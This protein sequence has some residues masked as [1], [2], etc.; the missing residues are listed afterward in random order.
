[1]FKPIWGMSPILTNILQMGWNHQ[2]ED[3]G[4][5]KGHVKDRHVTDWNTAFLYA[6][7]ITFSPTPEVLCT[8]SMWKKTDT[9]VNVE[10]ILRL[11]HFGS[12]S[13]WWSDLFHLESYS[14]PYRWDVFLE[15]FGRCWKTAISPDLTSEYF[16]DI[17][18]GGSVKEEA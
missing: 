12:F 6:P 18:F 5:Q 11:M 9:V 8:F 3:V 15:F 17:F 10:K 1:M 2:P 14:V 16:G 4:Q 13:R 7:R